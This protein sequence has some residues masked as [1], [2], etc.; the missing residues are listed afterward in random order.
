MNKGDIVKCEARNLP[1]RNRVGY[2]FGVIVLDEDTKAPGVW[3]EGDVNGH[4][5]AGRC[6]KE[7][8]W[9][10]PVEELTVIEEAQ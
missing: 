10:V 3:F 2:M 8:G 7:Q 6:P 4:D 5:L 1:T 9:F